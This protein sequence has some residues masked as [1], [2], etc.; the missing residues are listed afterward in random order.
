LT[1][2]R[3]VE[4]RVVDV[5]LFVVVRHG[6]HRVESPARSHRRLREQLIPGFHLSV[7][8]H[9]QRELAR[10]N[11]PVGSRRW[12]FV[13]YDQLSDRIGPLARTAPTEAAIVVVEAPWKAALRP[14]HRQ[15]L[16]LVLANSRHFALEQARRGVHVRHVVSKGTY[17]D[18]L[19]PIAEEVGGLVSM[20]PAERELRVDLARLVGRGLL[21]YEAHDGWLTNARDFEAACGLE[22]PFRMDAFYR[23]VRRS[24]GILMESGKPVGGRFSFD[25]ENRERWDGE[26][27]APDPPR[28][29]P[30]S[31]T[32]EVGELVTT[33]FARHPGRLDLAT[34]P[35]TADDAR[36]LWSWA[37]VACL[38]HF[39]PHEDAMSTRSRGIFHTR[40]SPLVNLHRLL[41]RDLV[42]DASSAEIPLSSR[43]GFVR[44]VLG[45]REFV[46]HVHRA[47]DGFR[48]H[49]AAE[50][51]RADVPGDAGFERWSGTAWRT[52]GTPVG[53][54]AAPNVLDARTPLPAAFWGDPSGLNCLDTVVRDVW[55]EGWSHHITRLMVLANIATLLDV[56]PRELTDWFWVAYVDAY[57]W[58]VEPNV[59]GMGTFAVGDLMTTKPY[60]AGSAYISRMSDY[61][62]GCRF[63]PAKDCP[64]KSLYWAFLDRHERALEGNPRM[65]MPMR[66]LARRSA[67]TRDADRSVFEHWR[68]VLLERR[69]TSAGQPPV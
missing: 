63:D 42:H 58:V 7:T 56:D 50:V 60:I 41:P 54:F 5:E 10:T 8:S 20:Q 26:P 15:K 4:D 36:T 38:E 27:A 17:A 48:R 28:F 57:D 2:D 69:G 44:Q 18:A 14:Y 46:H 30:D 53:D 1:V 24:T 40:V 39:G 68:R 62:A 37:K 16:A 25:G 29:E 67:T 43:E 3:A 23:H 66:S 31:I 55:E 12:I 9:F 59:L 32:L 65:L 11:P 61:C 35:A 52:S 6:A 64:L 34:L 51:P 49:V 45:W 21:E 47:T 22:A 19:G 33:R 13:A